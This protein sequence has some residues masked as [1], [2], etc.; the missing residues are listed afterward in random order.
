MKIIQSVF[1][2]NTLIITTLVFITLFSSSIM[3]ANTSTEKTKTG[4]LLGMSVTG[5]QESPKSLTIVPWRSPTMKGDSPEVT[6]VW[7][8]S[9]QLLDPSSYRRD[10]NLFLVQRHKNK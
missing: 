6:P 3:A 7:Q 1:I 9:L 2:H 5:N 8:P 4:A 10:I